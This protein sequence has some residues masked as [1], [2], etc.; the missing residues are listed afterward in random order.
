M[1]YVF[2]DVCSFY[3]VSYSSLLGM[4]QHICTT[5]TPS[6]RILNHIKMSSGKAVK[7]SQGHTDEKMV[8][9]HHDKHNSFMTAM[10]QST[11][12]SELT[13]KYLWR[14]DIEY[15]SFMW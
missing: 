10:D 8:C 7:I 6:L 15:E 2:L 1:I 13:F 11:L 4:P 9:N 14:V 12:L 3:N 5:E